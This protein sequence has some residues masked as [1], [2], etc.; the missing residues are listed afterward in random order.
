MA[1]PK[2]LTLF[3]TLDKKEIADFRGYLKRMRQNDAI[4]LEVF[5]YIRKQKREKN[6]S[7]GVICNGL[8]GTETPVARKNLL[9]TLSDLYLWLK[10]FLLYSKATD[11]K[12]DS[13]LLWLKILQE[14]RL[15]NEFINLA[16]SMQTGVESLSGQGMEDYLKIITVNHLTL[17]NRP[18][19]KPLPDEKALLRFR[20]DVDMFYAL[21]QLKVACELANVKN[22]HIPETEPKETSDPVFEFADLPI[23]DTHSL[24]LLYREVYRLIASRQEESYARVISLITRHITRIDPSE[25]HALFSYL[26]NYAAAQIRNKKPSYWESTHQLNKFGVEHGIF[27]REGEF[28]AQQ[29]NNIV[30]VA[31]RQNDFDWADAFVASHS[32]FL[33]EP[34][35]EE[36]ALLTSAIILFEKKAFEK[37]LDTLSGRVFKNTLDE[38][39]SRALILRS[40]Y[41]LR[42]N[43]N[44]MLDYCLSFEKYMRHGKHSGRTAIIGALNAIQVIKML[45]RRKASR[46]RIIETIEASK[47][48]YFEPWLLEK[49]MRYTPVS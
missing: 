10:D 24:V 15:K 5:D 26:H 29:F 27:T 33:P 2:F 17:Y 43:G 35:R 25:L 36:T 42:E 22:Q 45:I 1:D 7:A 39:R 8:Y 30:A 41:E 44:Y 40:L 18:A 12:F 11:G 48:I 34:I 28:S 9:N 23:P 31:C 49:A 32:S 38:I 19:D 13:R 46:K 37:V 16:S 4:A 20:T 6:L 21:A 14:R 47:P 3:R